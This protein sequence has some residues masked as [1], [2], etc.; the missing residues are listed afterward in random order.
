M[1]LYEQ[2]AK[3]KRLSVKALLDTLTAWRVRLWILA[4]ILILPGEMTINDLRWEWQSSGVPWLD[5]LK[6]VKADVEAVNNKIMSRTRILKRMGLEWSEVI[7]ELEAEEKDIASRGLEKAPSA[8][9][10]IIQ[11]STD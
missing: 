11:Y 2:S 9:S 7:D 3:E 6:E 1:L 10:D 5:P 8:R 4:G